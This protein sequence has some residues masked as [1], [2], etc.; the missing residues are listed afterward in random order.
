MKQETGNN[1]SSREDKVSIQL[2]LGGHSFSEENLKHVDLKEGGHAEAVVLTSKA[3]L[4][5]VSASPQVKPARALEICGMGCSKDEIAV[6]SPAVDDRMCAMAVD[7]KAHKLLVSR[8]GNSIEFVSPLL[9]VSGIEHVGAE[10]LITDKVC[11]MALRKES[12]LRAEAI[13]IST[14]EDF[15]YFFAREWKICSMDDGSR[16]RIKADKEFSKLLSR[17]FKNVE[18]VL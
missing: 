7:R 4:V 2:K 3:T 12:L 14:P 5:P 15:L 13:S 1:I 17:F 10:I 18:C 16:I 9:T 6:Y 8:F 11:Y